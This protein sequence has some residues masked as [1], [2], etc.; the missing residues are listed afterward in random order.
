MIKQKADSD[1]SDSSGSLPNT[2]SDCE[3]LS[4]RKMIQRCQLAADV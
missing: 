2:D 3:G 1:L 4:E